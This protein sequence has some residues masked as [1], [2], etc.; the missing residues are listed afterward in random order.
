MGWNPED[1]YFLNSLTEDQYYE[2][3]MEIDGPEMVDIIRATTLLSGHD[4]GKWGEGEVG[5]KAQRALRRIAG[6]SKLNE[7]R[8]RPYL[9]EEQA[10]SEGGVPSE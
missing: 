4:A 9:I 8:L 10:D 3:F 1:I 6:E 2:I 7:L 5:K